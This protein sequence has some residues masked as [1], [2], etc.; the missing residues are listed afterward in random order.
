MRFIGLGID[1]ALPKPEE[2]SGQE[3]LQWKMR[4]K[5]KAIQGKEKQ[6]QQSNLFAIF[7]HS[8]CHFS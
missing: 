2:V 1:E 6:L 8:L 3:G 7:Y 5:E 4:Y